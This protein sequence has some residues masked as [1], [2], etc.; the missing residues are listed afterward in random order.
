MLTKGKPE[1]G[2]FDFKVIYYFKVGFDREA[3]R[4]KSSGRTPLWMI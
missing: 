1:A 3:L 4:T 2:C